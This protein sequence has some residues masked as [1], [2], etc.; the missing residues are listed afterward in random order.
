MNFS[1]KESDFKE[2]ESKTRS[3]CDLGSGNG[4]KALEEWQGGEPAPRDWKWGQGRAGQAT[5]R[6]LERLC[7]GVERLQAITG[8]HVNNCDGRL[9][10]RVDFLL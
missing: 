8:C 3:A 2:D 10:G 7:G 4:W 1:L 5:T 9:Q 6:V